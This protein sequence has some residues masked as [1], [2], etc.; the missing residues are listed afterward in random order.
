[1]PK[2]SLNGLTDDE[3]MEEHSRYEDHLKKSPRHKPFRDSTFM[4]FWNPSKE[5]KRRVRGKK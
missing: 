2:V 4:H 3:F 1:M 5:N